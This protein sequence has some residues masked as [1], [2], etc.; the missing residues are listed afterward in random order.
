MYFLPGDN[1]GKM[2][3]M[4]AIKGACCGEWG[5]TIFGTLT[6]AEEALAAKERDDG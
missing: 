4:I 6:E 1:G 2:R 3:L 5:K